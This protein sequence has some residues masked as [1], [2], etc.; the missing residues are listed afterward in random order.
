MRSCWAGGGQCQSQQWG[1]NCSPNLFTCFTHI[2]DSNSIPRL[3]C[4]LKQS[5][6]GKH[7]KSC[8]RSYLHNGSFH[9]EQTIKMA[10]TQIFFHDFRDLTCKLFT[11]D[12]KFLEFSVTLDIYE[13]IWSIQQVRKEM[14]NEHDSLDGNGNDYFLCVS[15]LVQW[16]W[17]NRSRNSSNSKIWMFDT[18]TVHRWKV[19][20]VIS[21]LVLRPWVKL[22]ALH[23][24]WL[25]N[26]FAGHH[27][28]QPLMTFYGYIANVTLCHVK[29]CL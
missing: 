14:K 16:R 19:A 23:Q 1:K 9:L 2:S 7:V 28:N 20:D 12:C 8:C 17:A 15:T 21:R 29:I 3:C 27:F 18:N 10:V 26:F 11:I 6:L 5:R 13:L 22:F 4:S 24:F 25:A